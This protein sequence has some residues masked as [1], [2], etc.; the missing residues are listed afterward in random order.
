MIV[1]SG[2]ENENVPRAGC[3]CNSL[4]RETRILC[5]FRVYFINLFLPFLWA[6]AN[7]N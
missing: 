4:I 6:M 3:N 1:L 2:I 5:G 7:I